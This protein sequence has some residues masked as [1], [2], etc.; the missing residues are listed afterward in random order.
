MPAISNENIAVNYTHG[1]KHTIDMI[2]LHIMEGSLPKSGQYSWFNDPT[3]KASSHYGIRKDGRVIEWVAPEHT[4]WHA[5]L[6]RNPSA[7]IVK[8]RKGINPNDY[9]IG[10]EHE[11]FAS[12]TTPEAQVRASAE[13]V[14]DLCFHFGIPC[15]HDHVIGHREIR[16]DKPCPGKLPI[17]K[18]ITLAQDM[19]G[20]KQIPTLEERVKMLEEQVSDILKKIS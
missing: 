17:T 2:V 6:V 1:R 4:A 3:A 8:E 12:D 5:G 7:K 18:I 11:G 15:D 16:S 20:Q 10:I 19:L 14:A 13:L 9:S